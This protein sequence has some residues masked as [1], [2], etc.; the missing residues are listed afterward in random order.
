MVMTIETTLTEQVMVILRGHYG[1]AHPVKG[2][3]I[4]TKLGLKTDRPVRLAIRE[5]IAQG[6]PIASSVVTPLGY[7]LV[8]TYAETR[9]Y[10]AV[11]R[12]RLIEDA[13]RRRDFKRGAGLYFDKTVQRRML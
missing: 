11:L 4:A 10:L 12:S 13:K 5:L 7:Y 8:E 3:E 6:I 9:E 2:R 1:H